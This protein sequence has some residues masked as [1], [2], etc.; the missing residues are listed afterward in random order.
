[1]SLHDELR[2]A[3]ASPA[4]ED[5]PK[6]SDW[7]RRGKIMTASERLERINDL[8]EMLKY[9]REMLLAEVVE[10][11]GSAE[12]ILASISVQAME[13]ELHDLERGLWIDM[14]AAA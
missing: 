13:R 14:R 6:R 7:L 1:V 2:G 12:T 10:D 9:E 3:L 11:P 4:W 5:G 8:R